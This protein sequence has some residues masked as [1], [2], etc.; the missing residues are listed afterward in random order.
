MAA[1]AIRRLLSMIAV[2]FVISVLTFLLLEAIPN[3][4]PALRLAGR[5]AAADQI[6]QIREKYGF[7]KPIYVQYAR[8]MKNIFTGQAY[9]YT[10]GFSVTSEIEQSLPATVSLVLGAGV[11]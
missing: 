11:L 6:H 9:S 8:T 10:Q 4:D 1:F 7:D 2:M 3:G 5:L